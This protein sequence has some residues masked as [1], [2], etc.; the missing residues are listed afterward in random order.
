MEGPGWAKPQG[1]A[2]AQLL[3]RSVER[4]LFSRV[5]T[6]G[7]A[8]D[9]TSSS[10]GGSSAGAGAPST[11]A[12]SA[13]LNLVEVKA[14][15]KVLDLY[16]VAVSQFLATPAAGAVMRAEQLSREVL[17]VWAAYCLTH[18]AAGRMPLVLQYGVLGKRPWE[19]LRHLVLGDREAVDAALAVAAYLQRAALRSGG[20]VLFS[21]EDGGAA[22]VAFAR[23]FASTS[24]RLV[25]ILAQ[26]E[27]DAE[28]RVRA[29]WAEVR[30]KQQLA[31]QY[32]QELQQLEGEGVC[33]DAEQKR[34]QAE[35]QAL[36][37]AQLAAICRRSRSLA[38]SDPAT[39]D[40]HRVKLRHQE[41]ET[42][43]LMQRNYAKQQAVKARL[44]EAETPPPAV[45]QPL[46]DPATCRGDAL[47]WLFFLHMP[48]LLRR[49]SRLSFL[50][51]Q[52]LL[53]HPCSDHPDVVQALN[54]PGLNT[55]I[56]NHYNTYS[57][58]PQYG[59]TPTQRIRGQDGAV[60][61]RSAGSAPSDVGPR[62]ID[63][64]HTPSDGVWYPGADMRM[65]MAWKGSG[66]AADVGLQLPSGY[67]N[68]WALPAGQQW[69][70]TKRFTEQLK[71][72]E[73]SRGAASLQW[74]MPLYGSAE[75]THATRGNTGIARQGGGLG[76]LLPRF[77]ECE[78]GAKRL[79]SMAG[80]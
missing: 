17:V 79:M 61:L 50:A 57:F 25:G 7:A 24:P 56:T 36:A 43:R 28:A 34:L 13:S 73:G 5:V 76:A 49:L 65:A 47:A 12:A 3:L 58:C 37:A 38:L 45:I 35:L 4:E 6:L 66:C 59:L 11:A 80:S 72:G 29:H 31:A 52:M 78:S 33:L 62:H 18:A 64:F 15:E 40:G 75:Q 41:Q 19:E 21:L 44:A 67:F 10:S 51:Q 16:R 22:T 68:P 26:E 39:G 60:L 70:V 69:L 77:K 63:H 20:R 1:D 53:P 9:A 48:S 14:L 42:H 27:A 54:V 23:E 55:S 74:A 2:A 71:E 46:P 32:R 30:R 8:A